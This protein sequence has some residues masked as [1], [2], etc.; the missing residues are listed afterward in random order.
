[1]MHPRDIG[2]LMFAT[3]ILIAPV[4]IG[5]AMLLQTSRMD[6]VAWRRETIAPAALRKDLREIVAHNLVRSS[7]IIHHTPS[8]ITVDAV[9]GDDVAVRGARTYN[10]PVGI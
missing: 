7:P 5:S 4:I 3:M 2:G 8:C 1:M 6:R 9:I 10:N